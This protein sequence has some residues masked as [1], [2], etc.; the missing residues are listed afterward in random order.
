VISF[1][2]TTM[3]LTP[4]QSIV[5]LLGFVLE[6][7]VCGFAVR[8]K[9]FR[10]FPVFTA[11]AF[12]VPLRALLMFGLYYTTGYGSSTAFYSYWLTQGLE[13]C[14]RGASIGELALVV[15]RPY[16]GFRM[17]LRWVLP[18]IALA[19]LLRAGFT[20]AQRAAF[21]PGFVL[22]LERELELTAALVLCVLL[23]L[24]R[25]Y[26][27]E[28][29]TRVRY[30]A[31]GLLF[32]SLF[33][34]ANNA[35]SEIRFHAALRVWAVLRTVS[36]CIAALIWLIGLIRSEQIPPRT[37]PPEDVERHRKLMTEGTKAMDKIIERLRRFRR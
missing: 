29:Q 11:Y 1:A 13:L 31:A 30:L 14:L 21:L 25:R 6:L 23:M 22:V 24:S 17:V 9:L 27:V 12:V 5:W 15:S 8:R 35:I 32:Y 2:A 10:D 26:D 20:A 18:G 37:P 33:Q 36:F 28:V 4:A 34:V 7:L 3:H 16:A 19:L